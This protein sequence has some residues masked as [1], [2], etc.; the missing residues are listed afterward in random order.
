MLDI[1]TFNDDFLEPFLEKISNEN[2]DVFLIGDFNTDLINSDIEPISSFLDTITTNLFVLH[3]TLP[4][5]ITPTSSTLIDNIY[6]NI[7]N[8][9]TGIS[10]N[11]TSAISDHFPQFLILPKEIIEDY[12]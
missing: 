4:T 1:D 2:K 7:T 6:S 8:F 3:I 5:R 11:L 12:K 9:S 10:G